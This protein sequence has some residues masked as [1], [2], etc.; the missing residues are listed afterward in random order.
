MRKSL[1]GMD[2][3]VPV[4]GLE[5]NP[6]RLP[7]SASP[8]YHVLYQYHVYRASALYI[9]IEQACFISHEVCSAPCLRKPC[10]PAINKG[11]QITAHA[12]PNPCSRGG[13]EH[14]CLTPP[15]L[16]H[17]LNANAVVMPI[18]QWSSTCYRCGQGER[19]QLMPVV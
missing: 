2:W 4:L 6:L 5:S 19:G 12:L 15:L 9:C 18:I 13:R 8:V 10:K 14:S 7:F 11:S 3:S 1:M 17:C 16:K